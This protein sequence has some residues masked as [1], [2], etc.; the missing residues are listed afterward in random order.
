MAGYAD[1]INAQTTWTADGTAM[2]LASAE[3]VRYI[4]A[5]TIPREIWRDALLTTAPLPAPLS[6]ATSLS[7]PQPLASRG[8]R[9]FHAQASGGSSSSV[10]GWNAN[11]SH[12]KPGPRAGHLR[13]WRPQRQTKPR[14]RTRQTTYPVQRGNE[15]LLPLQPAPTRLFQHAQVSARRWDIEGGG[16]SQHRG[17]A[18]LR[19]RA[20]AALFSG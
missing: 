9:H 18:V 5:T 6:L 11:D 7:G 2:S 12:T 4:R 14:K 15:F 10:H 3:E 20:A 17:R 16:R 13:G 8:R 1:L 19:R